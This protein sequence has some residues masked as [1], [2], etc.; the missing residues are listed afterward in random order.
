MTDD[1]GS[2]AILFC[3]FRRQKKTLKR[4]EPLDLPKIVVTCHE[5]TDGPED[6]LDGS[7]TDARDPSLELEEEK[8]V[9]EKTLADRDQLSRAH[10]EVIDQMRN[11][12]KEARGGDKHSSGSVRSRPPSTIDDKPAVPA[13]KAAAVAKI[14]AAIAQSK[15][16]A[17]SQ[18]KK[19]NCGTSLDSDTRNNPK[20]VKETPCDKNSNQP[21]PVK[22]AAVGKLKAA[23][24]SAAIIGLDC[25]TRGSGGSVE[26]RR[27]KISSQSM[28]GDCRDYRGQED[29]VAVDAN[30]ARRSS[31]GDTGSGKQKP[32][33][34]DFFEEGKN[35]SSCRVCGYTVGKK[36][37]T[38]GLVRHLS[39]VHQ[40]EYRQYTM[41]MEKNW[42]HGMMEKSLKMR[43]PKNF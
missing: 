39:L 26:D 30:T 41:R 7:P 32:L 24:L 40:R 34:W 2:V 22:D 10:K 11:A 9:K 38:G 8:V 28:R 25:D 19:A 43:I 20:I 18:G 6:E 33:I 23:I 36:T 29:T 3:C 31:D 35:K 4:E 5:D 27:R 16:S 21:N 37:N 14:R 17:E 1:E 12:I 42:T 15:M 13:T